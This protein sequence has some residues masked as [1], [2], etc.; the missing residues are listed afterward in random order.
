VAGILLRT[1]GE[2]LV[3]L[4]ALLLGQAA[5]GPA[6]LPTTTALVLFT[7]ELGVRLA[8]RV[9][10]AIF[11]LYMQEELVAVDPLHSPEWART[12]MSS[13]AYYLETGKG[14]AHVRPF[15]AEA[16]GR[17]MR[18]IVVSFEDDLRLA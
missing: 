10:M 15:F 8:S 9:P 17:V 7:E 1:V 12:V 14:F 18:R 13:L 6:D 5:A 3:S 16:F 4:A 11:D 2:R